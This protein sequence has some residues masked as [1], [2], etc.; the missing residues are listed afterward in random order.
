MTKKI[1]KLNTAS[2]CKCFELLTFSFITSIMKPL[3]TKATAILKGKEEDESVKF[4]K[5]DI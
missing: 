5:K 4:S 3:V 1:I 2:S